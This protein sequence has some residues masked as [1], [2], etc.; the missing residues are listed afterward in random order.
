MSAVYSTIRCERADG[1]VRI[2]LNRPPLN[3]LGLPMLEELNQALAG[4]AQDAGLRLLVMDHEGKAFSAGADVK[5]HTPAQ[6]GR[7]LELFHGLFRKL[8]A[9]SAPTLAAVDGPALG[10]GCELATFCDLVLASERA[11]FGQ[12]EVKVGV[13]APV[14]AAMLPRL[15]GRARALELLWTGEILGAVEAER[16]GLVNRVY[17]A[18]QFRGQVDQWIGRLSSLSGPVLKLTKR[19]VD[20]ARGR[21]FE[22]A[23]EEVERIYLDELL[24]TADAH[25]GIQAFLEK[26]PPVWQHR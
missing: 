2:T 4:L 13:F 18:A 20:Q 1:V 23:L 12:P 15:V 19:A 11:T 25:E 10:G 5:D 16:M 8:G 6:V 21:A 22:A 17:A 9:V 7:M 3:I 14:A 24:K 26:R